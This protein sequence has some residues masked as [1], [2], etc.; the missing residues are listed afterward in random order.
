VFPADGRQVAA[1]ARTQ[2]V[3]WDAESGEE[4]ARREPPAGAEYVAAAVDAGS[5]RFSHRPPSTAVTATT[6]ASPP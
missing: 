4:L 1:V 2:A 5:S 6:T 3:V